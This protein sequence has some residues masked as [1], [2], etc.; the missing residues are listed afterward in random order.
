MKRSLMFVLCLVCFGCSATAPPVAK[1][2]SQITGRAPVLI[3]SFTFSRVPSGHILPIFVDAEDQDGDLVGFWAIVSQLGGNIY[4]HHYV[5]IKSKEGGTSHV[6]GYM[7][8]NIPHLHQIEYL[9][10][11]LY[12]VDSEGSKSNKVLHNV[13]IGMV[14]SIRERIPERWEDAKGNH[15]GVIFFQFD[16]GY[17][18]DDNNDNDGLD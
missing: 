15:I 8:L 16:R 2:P 17:D 3:D 14:T 4:S 12:A 1:D 9:R 18:G 13:E 5:P 7:T 6:K 10:I 11:E